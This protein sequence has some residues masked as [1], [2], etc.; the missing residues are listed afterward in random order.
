ME[1]GGRRQEVVGVKRQ[2]V[3]GRRYPSPFTLTSP[4]LTLT[5]TAGNH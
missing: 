4:P 2:E 3:G 1:A 5:L